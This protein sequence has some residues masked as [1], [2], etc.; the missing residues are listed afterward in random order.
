MFIQI[1]RNRKFEN[2]RERRVLFSSAP[3]P[4]FFYIKCNKN[5]ETLISDTECLKYVHT[6]LQISESII[7]KEQKLIR[8]KYVCIWR[9]ELGSSSPGAR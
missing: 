7:S 9:E 1:F 8:S 6:E 4:V 5:A 3:L 2:G